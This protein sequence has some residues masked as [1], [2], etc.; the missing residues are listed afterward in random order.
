MDPTIY[1][2][3]TYETSKQT[4]RTQVQAYSCDHRDTVLLQ[5]LIGGLGAETGFDTQ[6]QF[7]DEHAVTSPRVLVRRATKSAVDAAV[8][9][10]LVS[11]QVWVSDL[12]ALG[13]VMKS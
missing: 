3:G 6:P 12:A 2:G 8:Q 1:I 9:R 5:D 11:V 13:Q 7:P 4:W 10:Q